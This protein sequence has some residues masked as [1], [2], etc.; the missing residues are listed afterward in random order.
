[1]F[2]GDMGL[3]DESLE[4]LVVSGGHLERGSVGK[5]KNGWVGPQK[6]IPRSDRY[7]DDQCWKGNIMG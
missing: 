2:D 7:H 3:I 5:E 6:K 4:F 1:M